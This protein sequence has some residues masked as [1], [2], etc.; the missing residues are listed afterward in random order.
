MTR[1]KEYVQYENVILLMYYYFTNQYSINQS[2][3][4]FSNPFYALLMGLLIIQPK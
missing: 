2:I 1:K 4:Y 3:L